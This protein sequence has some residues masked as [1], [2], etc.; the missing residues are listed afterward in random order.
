MAFSHGMNDAQKTMGIIT[1]ALFIFGMIPAIAVPLWV[2]IAC[3]TVIML[4]T[5]TGGWKIIKTIGTKFFRMEP[6]H[7]F[8]IQTA[9]ALVIEGATHFGAPISTSHVISS[10]VLGSGSVRNISAVRWGVAK[11]IILAWFITIPASAV[12]AGLSF[13]LIRMIHPKF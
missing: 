10:A 11:N 8:A 5:V 1:L 13:F 6:L 3:A 4:G 9:S 12:M 2:K 7:G